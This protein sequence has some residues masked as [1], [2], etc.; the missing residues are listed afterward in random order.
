MKSSDSVDSTCNV[1]FL[2]SM[3]EEIHPG[4]KDCLILLFKVIIPNEA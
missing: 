1:P 4:H 2:K 3:S